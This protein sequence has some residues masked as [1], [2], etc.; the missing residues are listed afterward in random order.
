MVPINYQNDFMLR[1][2]KLTDYGTVMMTHMARLPERIYT[3]T[4]VSAAVHIAM[5]T[6]SKMLK[7][8][9]KD[10]LLISHRGAKGGYALARRPEEI[11]VAEIIIAIDG[12]IAFT[13]CSGAHRLCAQERSCTI[14][15]NWQLINRT[16]QIALSEVSLAQMIK[17][18]TPQKFRVSS[19]LPRS[20]VQVV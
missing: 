15:G 11:S 8:L 16:V 12:P 18:V 7:V 2:S 5:P 14:R 10:G 20:K 3:A 4:E 9:A 13:E 6:V 17:P 1:V 19:A